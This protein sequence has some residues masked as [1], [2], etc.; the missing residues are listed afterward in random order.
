MRKTLLKLFLIALAPVFLTA[1]VSYDPDRADVND[2]SL[3]SAVVSVGT[4]QVEAKATVTRNAKRQRLLLYNDSSSVVYY[5]PTGVTVSGATRGVPVYKK[6]TVVI[7]VGDVAVFLIAGS[8]SN[9]V[10]VQE[11][12]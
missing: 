11:L 10:I 3:A 1:G 6:Q 8:A 4:T 5:G 2:I 12:E 7:P 9:D